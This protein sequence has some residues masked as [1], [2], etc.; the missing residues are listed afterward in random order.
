MT[1]C[2]D[3]GYSP[4]IRFTKSFIEILIKIKGKWTVKTK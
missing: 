4:N 2:Y 1:I 3:E